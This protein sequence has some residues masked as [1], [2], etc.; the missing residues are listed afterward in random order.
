[1]P[2]AGRCV[3]ARGPAVNLD[4]NLGSRAA[5]ISAILLEPALLAAGRAHVAE[6]WPLMK[7]KK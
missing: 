1:M 3:R 2:A 7:D 4:L 5:M 6:Q